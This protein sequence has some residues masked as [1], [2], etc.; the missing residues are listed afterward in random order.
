MLAAPSGS[1]VFAGRP[2]HTEVRCGPG[3]S[4]SWSTVVELTRVSWPVRVWRT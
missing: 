1:G 2:R 4:K 3:Y